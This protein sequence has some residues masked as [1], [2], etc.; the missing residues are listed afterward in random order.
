MSQT[1]ADTILFLLYSYHTLFFFCFFTQ[2]PF[3]VKK[4]K[5]HG[6]F[7]NV[8]QEMSQDLL[9]LRLWGRLIAPSSCSHA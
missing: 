2:A 4:K 7:L 3:A 1:A 5:Y 6:I 9:Q 8:C